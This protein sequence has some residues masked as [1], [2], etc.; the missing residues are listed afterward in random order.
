MDV[1]E[2]D[3]LGDRIGEHWYYVSKGAALLQF[4]D[5]FACREVLDVGAGSG[6]FSKRL[7]AG[8][9]CERAICVDTAYAA[10][11]TELHCGKPIAFVRRVERVTQD[12][13][14]MMDVIEHVDDDVAFIRSYTDRMPPGARL[15][16]TVPAFQFLWSGHDVFLEHK[17]R[18]TLASLH[19]TIDCA[20]LEVIRA[21]YF[22]GALLPI[23]CIARLWGRLRLASSG[24]APRS[25]LR[26]HNAWINALLTRIH[27]VERHTLF[28]CNRWA[29]LTVFCLARKRLP[30]SSREAMAPGEHSALARTE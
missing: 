17:R 14:L 9:S 13:I 28:G 7:L 26:L 20:G 5:G 18:Y 12:L 3:I 30:S 24:F 27:A 22:F 4:L 15:L 8:G 19:R 21:R 1:K 10:E 29:G 6:V 11:R 2:Q 25:D 16:V 23:V